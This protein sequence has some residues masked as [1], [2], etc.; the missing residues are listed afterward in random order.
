MILTIL[1]QYISLH[2]YNSRFCIHM[3]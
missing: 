2:C 1:L 3:L